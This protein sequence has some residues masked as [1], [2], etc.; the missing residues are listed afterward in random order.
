MLVCT[1]WYPCNDAVSC[2][3]AALRRQNSH[4]PG[5][6]TFSNLMSIKQSVSGS[7][8]EIETCFLC[9]IRLRKTSRTGCQKPN[10]QERLNVAKIKFRSFLHRRDIYMVL[11][12][13]P[14]GKHLWCNR[15]GNTAWWHVWH[16]LRNCWAISSFR[17]YKR[18]GRTYFGINADVRGSWDPKSF[19]KDACSAIMDTVNNR[20]VDVDFVGSW[21][22]SV[23]TTKVPD[24]PFRVKKRF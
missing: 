8:T 10:K 3:K 17:T 20:R 22:S 23:T 15:I 11:L 2:R 14:Y 12:S 16:G 1:T 13:V 4:K 9:S 24:W 5:Y 18:S 7:K 21:P 19:P 6:Q